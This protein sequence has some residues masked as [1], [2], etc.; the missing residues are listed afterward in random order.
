[1][2][3]IS[4]LSSTAWDKKLFA[5]IKPGRSRRGSLGFLL[6]TREGEIYLSVAGKAAAFE[7]RN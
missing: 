5:A 7:V 2:A 1:M 6:R 4:F 3:V